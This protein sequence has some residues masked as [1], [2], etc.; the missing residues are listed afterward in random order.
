MAD[1]PKSTPIPAAVQEKMKEG[2]RQRYAMGTVGLEK[3]KGER[4]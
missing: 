3:P 1:R 2:V 4:K